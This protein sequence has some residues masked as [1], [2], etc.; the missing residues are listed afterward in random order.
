MQKSLSIDDWDG[1]RAVFL[2]AISKRAIRM[3][4]PEAVDS[5]LRERIRVARKKSSKGTVALVTIRHQW[6][7]SFRSSAEQDIEDRAIENYLG[8]GIWEWINP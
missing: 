8:H 7:E 2:D 3:G 5:W 4:P 6:V 1:I